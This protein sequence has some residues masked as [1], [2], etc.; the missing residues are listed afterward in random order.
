MSP[1]P[2][3]G[4]ADVVRAGQCLAA[5]ARIAVVYRDLVDRHPVVRE[6]AAEV[7]GLLDVLT[8]INLTSPEPRLQAHVTR[9]NQL[10][11]ELPQPDAGITGG[12]SDGS[13]Q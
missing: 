9:I 6:L 8:G 11:T 4:D 2:E 5:A 1:T 10:R 7:A 3:F 13:R 12:Y